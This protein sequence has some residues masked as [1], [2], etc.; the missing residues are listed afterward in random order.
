MIAFQQSQNHLKLLILFRNPKPNP[1][2]SSW[3]T[4]GRK[5]SHSS[6]AYPLQFLVLGN[7]DRQILPPKKHIYTDLND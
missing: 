2:E 4:V 7:Q 6:L 5:Q 3:P 1:A